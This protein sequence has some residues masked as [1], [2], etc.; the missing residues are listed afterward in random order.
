VDDLLDGDGPAKIDHTGDPAAE[1]DPIPV[2]GSEGPER[3]E[4]ESPRMTIVEHLTEL[5]KRL[6][7]AIGAIILGMI[8]AFIGKDYVFEAINRPLEGSGL[9]AE[10][11]TLGVA[12]P[13]MTVLKVSIYAGLLVS[14]P[15]V[16]YEF[17]AF[18]MPALYEKEKKRVLPYVFFTFI[19]F[20]AGVVFAYF[21][22]LPV[23]LRFL[24]GY[25]GEMFTQQLRA[26][27]YISFVAAFLLSFGVVFEI[28]AVVLLLS[29]ADIVSAKGLRKGRKYAILVIAVASMVLTPSGDPLTMTMMMGPLFVLYEFGILLAS[30]T[31]RRRRKRA[32]V[33]ASV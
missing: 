31:E 33:A 17:W 5:R 26:S 2:Q 27:E 29:V 9:D 6:V 21:L 22:V 11:V 7:R 1:A 30:L 3:P 4:E 8:A 14:L 24:V 28:P 16:L 20:A 13:F 10:L 23:G 19:L 32:A 25:G 15:V 12:E 18:I